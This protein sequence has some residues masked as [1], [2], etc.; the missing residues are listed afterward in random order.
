MPR[1]LDTEL[2]T[3][4]QSSGTQPTSRMC[5]LTSPQRWPRKSDRK[6]RWFGRRFQK[7]AREMEDNNESLW[8]VGWGE[9]T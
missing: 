2:W 4:T 8:G 9:V 1:G 3:G 7:L 6:G 5:D